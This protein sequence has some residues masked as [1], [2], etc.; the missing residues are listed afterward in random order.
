MPVDRRRPIIVIAT[1]AAVVLAAVPAVVVFGQGWLPLPHRAISPDAAQPYGGSPEAWTLFALF[2]L[3]WMA[4]DV[5]LLVLV[6]DRIG[7]RYVPREARPAEPRRK[8]RRRT[9]GLGYLEARERARAEAAPAAGRRVTRT[10]PPDRTAGRPPRRPPTERGVETPPVGSP[11]PRD[12]G[13]PPAPADPPGERLQG[14][15]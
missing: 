3:A 8:R 1:A 7:F 2:Y 11:A 15:I 14:P 5:T 9:A 10:I 13:E 6:Y 4:V 12:G